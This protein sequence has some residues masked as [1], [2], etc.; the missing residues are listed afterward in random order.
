MANLNIKEI[1]EWMIEKAKDMY[2]MVFE[3]E[4]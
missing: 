4:E 3:V 2:Y 1:V